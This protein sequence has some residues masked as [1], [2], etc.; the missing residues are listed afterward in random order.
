M[1]LYLASAFVLEG[2]EEAPVAVSASA[3]WEQIS[4]VESRRILSV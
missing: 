2:P 1:A 3:F 4:F